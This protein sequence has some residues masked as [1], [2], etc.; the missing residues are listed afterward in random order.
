MVEDPS[1]QLV[2]RR[3][4]VSLFIHVSVEGSDQA[5]QV[6]L[7]VRPLAIDIAPFKS[8][9]ELLGV[10]EIGVDETGEDHAAEE[11]ELERRFRLVSPLPIES[12]QQAGDVRRELG[13]SHRIERRVGIVLETLRQRGECLALLVGQAGMMSGNYIGDS[14]ATSRSSAFAVSASRCTRAAPAVE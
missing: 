14:S 12:R 3:F 6:R 7:Q 4:G 5:R 11:G 13:F 10:P 9:V 2:D 8:R 1:A